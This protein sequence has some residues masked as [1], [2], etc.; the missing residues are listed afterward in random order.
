VDLINSIL[1]AI[2][3]ILF[4]PFSHLTP[5]WGLLAIAA[6]TGVGMLFVFKATSDQKGIKQ[7][8][9][10]V[11]GHFLAI[12][13]YKDE[14]SLMFNTMK[15]ILVSNLAY[16][17]KSLRPMLFLILPVGVIMVQLGSRYEHRPL[18]VGES[19]LVTLKAN[20]SDIDLMSVQIEVPKGVELEVPPVRALEL[21]EVTWRLHAQQ[22]GSFMLAFKYGEQRVEKSLYAIDKL[23][24]L[25]TQIS[26][27]NIEVKFLN[28]SEASLPGSSFAS[29]ISIT[30]PERGLNLFGANVHWLVAFFLTSLIAAFALK[31]LVG[32][33]V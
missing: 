31:G 12:R 30:Y 29:M 19:T 2:F 10:L 3:G 21:R 25:A 16:M 11:K 22:S 7:A 24:P 20:G 14:V 27:D 23:E 13:L 17:K 28:P 15:N 26:T 9:N 4:M 6:A 8:K 18:R 1:S 33:E 32:V 5:V